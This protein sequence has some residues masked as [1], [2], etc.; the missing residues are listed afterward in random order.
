MAWRGGGLVTIEAA[1]RMRIDGTI[2]TTGADGGTWSSAASGGGV[3]LSC[4]WLSGSGSVTANG[5]GSVHEWCRGAGGRIAIW[6][7]YDNTTGL[8]NNVAAAKGGA[9]AE[10]GTVFWGKRNAPGTVLL[11]R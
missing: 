6:Y 3:A 7:L 11:L 10:D 2:R 5:G 1:A 9:P 4:K 8:S